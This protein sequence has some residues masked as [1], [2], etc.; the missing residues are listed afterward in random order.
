MTEEHKPIGYDHDGDPN[1]GVPKIGVEKGALQRWH[2]RLASK[3][4]ELERDA[5]IISEEIRSLLT[6]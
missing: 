6:P 3:G 5:G 4:S 2:A 1:I